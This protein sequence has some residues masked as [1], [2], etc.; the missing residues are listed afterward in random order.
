MRPRQLKETVLILRRI[1]DLCAPGELSAGDHCRI[2]RE[3]VEL[4]RIQPDE[5]TLKLALMLAAKVR[6]EYPA[7]AQAAGL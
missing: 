3:C 4:A 5:T 2:A 6:I 1:V 7:Q